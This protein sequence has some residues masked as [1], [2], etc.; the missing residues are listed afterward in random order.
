MSAA[1][2]TKQI[3]CPNS[4][5]CTNFLGCNC[6][7]IYSFYDRKLTDLIA[8]PFIRRYKDLSRDD[9]P[10]EK[11]PFT[12]PCM[13]GVHCFK[14]APINCEKNPIDP[15][16][17]KSNPRHNT[18]YERTCNFC[19][20]FDHG[21]IP[22]PVRRMYIINPFDSCVRVR[23]A[24]NAERPPRVAKIS[25]VADVVVPE[26]NNSYATVVAKGV[27]KSVKFDHKLKEPV[28]KIPKWVDIDLDVFY[29]MTFE[30]PPSLK[31]LL[32]TTST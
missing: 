8:G 13:H 23:N 29:D 28:K 11:S 3:W 19:C 7:H 31:P 25:K 14:R 27:S 6:T 21:G 17:G 22:L 2:A 26:S 15:L 20:P 9:F 30:E 12:I 16:T 4:G 32:L 1:T 24:C 10:L 18:G 5:H